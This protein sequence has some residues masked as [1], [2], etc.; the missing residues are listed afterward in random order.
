MRADLRKVGLGPTLSLQDSTF[1]GFSSSVSKDDSWTQRFYDDP[2]YKA[3]DSR[4]NANA[5]IRLCD[6]CEKLDPLPT[7][8]PHL[9][10]T[11]P[12]Q[13]DPSRLDFI[14]DFMGDGRP[15]DDANFLQ[16]VQNI[17][18]QKSSTMLKRVDL[19]HLFQ[20]R[21]TVADII[22]MFP[23]PEALTIMHF[24]DPN[25][26]SNKMFA[27]DMSRL[28][29]D[30]AS[31]IGVCSVILNFPRLDHVTILGK[32]A[33]PSDRDDELERVISLYTET[34]ARHDYFSR[35]QHLVGVE[36]N[37]GATLV[38]IYLQRFKRGLPNAEEYSGQK[39]K[40]GVLTTR[41]V[42]TNAGRR[43][44]SDVLDHRIHI[45]DYPFEAATTKMLPREIVPVTPDPA[46]PET[47]WSRSDRILFDE[48][49]RFHVKKGNYTAKT[50]TGND[51]CVMALM[52]CNYWLRRRHQ[53]VRQLRQISTALLTSQ[54]H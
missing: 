27:K 15:E 21:V 8:C 40:R 1:I 7:V 47:T 30:H 4:V 24:I 51:D 16:E 45:S 32:I 44:V 43:L 10:Y 49:C 36:S 3:K 13:Q 48:L 19:V 39:D 41:D 17:P 28:A 12:P 2:K 35:C 50:S 5:L 14:Q 9:E 52:L 18:Q 46:K 37:M 20:S 42:K 33:V 6:K 22:H 29:R 53:A 31:N 26:G 54:S 23:Q 25:G 38:D 11:L 34:I